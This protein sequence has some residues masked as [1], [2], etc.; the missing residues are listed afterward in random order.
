[1]PRRARIVVVVDP[2]GAP[3]GADAGD[4]GEPER[5]D[6]RFADTRR[7]LERGVR[8]IVA[9]G[10]PAVLEA[11]AR[12]L[13][14]LRLRRQPRPGPRRERGGLAP[15]EADDRL[16]R[17]GE[18]GVGP[19]GRGWGA[20]GGHELGEVGVG[21]GRERGQGAADPDDLPR[22]LPRMPLWPAHAERSCRNAREV[23]AL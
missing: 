7:T 20:G 1:A 22:A 10:E 4:G 5:V 14:P 12:G 2:A 18:G 16:A 15:R 17:I 23:H 6:G 11:P 8:A 9:P 13:L 19:E 21:G 3:L